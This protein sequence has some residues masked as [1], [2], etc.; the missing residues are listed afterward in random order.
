M[1]IRTEAS[2]PVRRNWIV[3]AAV[4]CALFALLT[5][6]ARLDSLY[7]RPSKPSLSGIITGTGIHSSGAMFIDIR[8]TNTGRG[9]AQSVRINEV[10]MRTSAGTGPVTDSVLSPALPLAL[11]DLRVNVGITVRFFLSVPRTVNRFSIVENG[12]L[13]DSRGRTLQYSIAQATMVSFDPVFYVD[14]I[15]G[16]DSNPGNSSAPWKTIQKAADTIGPGDTVIVNAGTYDERVQVSRSG[17]QGSPMTFQAQGTVVMKGFTIN[18]GFIKIDGFEVANT[19]ANGDDCDQAA[20]FSSGESNQ[21]R[22]NYIHDV[23]AWGICLGGSSSFN[24]VIGNRIVHAGGVGIWAHGTD[25][26]IDSNDISRTVQY[27]SGWTNIPSWIDADGIYIDGM[28]LTISGNFVHDIL[29]TDPENGDPHIDCLQVAQNARAI[30]IVYE[31]NTCSI[32]QLDAPRCFQASMIAGSGGVQNFI[33]RNNIVLNMCRGFVIHGTAGSQVGVHIV[34]NTLYNLLDLGI[35][36]CN[37][38]GIEVKNNIFHTINQPYFTN[39]RDCSDYSG[40]Q[41]L[42]SDVGNNLAYQTAGSPHPNDIWGLDPL[43]IDAAAGNFHLQ[44]CSP[45]ID[46]GVNLPIAFDDF[47]GLQRPVGGGIDIGA[48]EYLPNA[49]PTVPVRKQ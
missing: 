20:I 36:A 7:A 21:V 31:R 38:P 28:R 46:A 25:H 39:V 5:I 22:N 23:A 48:F 6:G 37:A 47:D 17:T 13:Q 34:N 30:D 44:T 40:E 29:I 35:D 24:G 42:S 16:N 18:A 3:I 33:I 49:N 15:N 32:P 2:D 41:D 19:T 8:F 11:G 43:F 1:C 14:G 12:T 4:N 26:V 27:H 10:E 9:A 45:A